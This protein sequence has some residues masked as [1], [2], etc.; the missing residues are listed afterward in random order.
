MKIGIIDIETT[1]FFHNGGFIVEVGIASLDTETGDV[2]T[3]FD[4]TCRE[5]GMT[6][7]DR[8]AWIF[9]NS[10][11]TVE[12]V[13]ESPLFEDLKPEIQKHIDSFDAVTAYNKRFDFTFL[14]DRGII[15]GQE[16]P[17]PMLQATD[18]C[19][20][21]GRYGSFKWPKVEEAWTHFFPD[22]PYVELHRGADDALH[23]AKIVFKL[24]QLGKMTEEVAQ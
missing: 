18:V 4:S 8:E 24:F 20:L 22:E 5:D 9:Q 12:E 1:N 10:D 14:L 11:L 21:P 3:V 16:W 17:C 23:E 7:K 6:A 13:R 15:L 19:K 2:E